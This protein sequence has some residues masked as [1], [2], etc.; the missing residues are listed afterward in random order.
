MMMFRSFCLHPGL[1]TIRQTPRVRLSLRLLGGI[2]LCALMIGF[3]CPAQAQTSAPSAPAALQNA[4]AAAPAA[5]ERVQAQARA[6]DSATLVAGATPIRLWGIEPIDSLSPAVALKARTV[7]DNAIGP[8]K[9]TCEIKRRDG[10]SVLAQCVNARDQDLGLLMLQQ[11]YAVA[12]RAAV[13]GT[14]FEQPYIQAETSA[15]KNK[16]GVWSVDKTGGTSGNMFW[17]G[18]ALIVLLALVSALGALAFI[19]MRGFQK[20]T[21]AQKQNVEMASRERD[22]REKERAI[23]G[24]MLDSELKA[25][26]AKIEAYVAVYEE[27]LRGLRDPDRPPKYKKSGDIVQ[28]QPAL[29]RSVFVR[30]T[31]K[32]D[33]LG[34]RVSSALVH[35]YARIKSN[36]EYITLEPA[37]PLEEA[38]ATLEQCLARAKRLQDLADD[39]LEHFATSG[40]VTDDYQE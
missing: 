36:P 34:S 7:L 31:D 35:F 12:Q 16:I 2:A 23:V 27:M 28:K 29:E 9:V 37:M 25:N 40:I 26:K 13:Y 38:V 1:M 21:D 10:D 39:L 15:Q 20:M 11:G 30:N 6:A 22:V 8:D 3:V 17:Y 14:V 24:V 33:M 4:P 32:L 18:L 19:V 5:P